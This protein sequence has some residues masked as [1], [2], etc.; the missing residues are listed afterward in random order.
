M[1]DEETKKQ[2]RELL[3]QGPM[4]AIEIGKEI[5]KDKKTLNSILYRMEDLE[6]IK[7]SG[8]PKWR[9][10]S[11]SSP[12]VATDSTTRLS[13][14][15]PSPSATSSASSGATPLKD[16][17]KEELKERIVRL[18]PTERESACSTID[19]V[20]KLNDSSVAKKDVTNILHNSDIAESIAPAGQK[21]FWVKKG[22]GG[23]VTTP[24]SKSTGTKL[25]LK[26]KKLYTLETKDDIISFVPATDENIGGEGGEGAVKSKP[27]VSTD[28]PSDG[29][30]LPSNSSATA[31]PTEGM[32]SLSL[33]ETDL[34]EAVL[35][36]L[37][38]NKNKS[39]TAV[40]LKD[41]LNQPTRDKVYVVLQQLVKE[42][43]VGKNNDG[44]FNILD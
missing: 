12:T 43:K 34:R 31:P 18:L 20:R 16:T 9:L 30:S 7:T 3:K 10:K 8:A 33:S 32:S 4:T 27:T 17:K 1:A 39:F 36:H 15:P 19:I 29:S 2:I 22:F 25:E 21:P 37:S 24:S 40:D 38:K 26:G 35:N 11:S 42:G 13:D 14:A 23:E 28:S 44:T 6:S 5:K 41:L